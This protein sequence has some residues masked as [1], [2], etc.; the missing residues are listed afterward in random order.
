MSLLSP[1]PAVSRCVAPF[2]NNV[3]FKI[4]CPAEAAQNQ[5]PLRRHLLSL[6]GSWPI[7]LAARRIYEQAVI[8]LGNVSCAL[9][10]DVAETTPLPSVAC[11]GPFCL[12]LSAPC[13]CSAYEFYHL[14]KDVGL[15]RIVPLQY[16]K[17]C[18]GNTNFLRALNQT[19]GRWRCCDLSA[20][21]LLEWQGRY[22][23]RRQV[24]LDVFLC[25]CVPRLAQDQ[26]D[27]ECLLAFMWVLKGFL[28][29]MKLIQW[30]MDFSCPPKQAFSD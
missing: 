29:C 30:K 6:N 3:C 4:S 13:I 16:W 7:L 27:S 21:C 25:S 19:L 8:V 5:I 24:Q 28:N 9:Q 1:F 12:C 14:S 20:F 23:C 18:S 15:N 17:Q 11:A 22:V 26:L 10:R 2:L